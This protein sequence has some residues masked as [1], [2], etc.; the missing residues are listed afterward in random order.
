MPTPLPSS[1]DAVLKRLDLIIQETIES[2]NYLGIFAYVYRRTTAK[3]QASI[4][5]KRFDDNVQM[6]KF[7]VIFANRYIHAYDNFK[8]QQPISKSW[9]SVFQ[10]KDQPSTIIQHLMMGMNSHIN[11][12]LGLAAAEISSGKEI[13]DLKN[14]FMLVNQILQEITNEMQDRLSKVSK[15]MFLLDWIG[16]NKDEEIINFGIVKSREFAWNVAVG[17][18]TLEINQKAKETLIEKT[19][20][21][22]AA[23]NQLIQQPPSKILNFVL[24]I[25]SFF[26][27]KNI[28]KIINNLRKDGE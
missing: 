18:A 28:E 16:K 26:E 22:V 7:D 13:D 21:T 15:L 11:F 25:I 1:I 2:N 14:D 6:E 3:I 5:E 8:S 27:E 10:V 4:L 17:V 9:N 24:R 23:F 12:D 19:D 20:N